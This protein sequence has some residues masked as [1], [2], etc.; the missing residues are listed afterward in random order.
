M[1]ES[2]L[3]M[4]AKEHARADARA[5][6]RRDAARARQGDRQS[7]SESDYDV[8]A[9]EPASEVAELTGVCLAEM[10]PEDQLDC[11]AEKRKYGCSKTFAH[12]LHRGGMR[13]KPLPGDGAS[14]ADVPAIVAKE[15]P[16]AEPPALGDEPL[17]VHVPSIEWARS[18]VEWVR[19]VTPWWGSERPAT[20]QMISLNRVARTN[21][22]T[23][24]FADSRQTKRQGRAP[25]RKNENYLDKPTKSMSWTKTESESQAVAKRR[26]VRTVSEHQAWVHPEC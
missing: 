3:A 24:R 16:L 13:E 5:K 20:M 18:N 8:E 10:G 17:R 25:G 11:P 14:S 4:L 21:T 22:W 1:L 15:P 6:A 26:R 23:A 2:V 19:P 12:V 9:D 7:D